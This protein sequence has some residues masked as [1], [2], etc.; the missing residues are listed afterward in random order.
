MPI[1]GF[2]TDA[3]VHLRPVPSVSVSTDAYVHRDP[4]QPCVILFRSRIT[5]NEEPLP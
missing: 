4:G 1:E 3:Y 5:D 2:G